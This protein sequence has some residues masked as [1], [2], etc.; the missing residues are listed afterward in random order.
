MIFIFIKIIFDKW[1][2]PNQNNDENDEEHR[3]AELFPAQLLRRYFLYFKPQTNATLK[4]PMKTLAVRGVKGSHLGKLIT[5]RGIIIRVSDV[6]PAVEVNA[7]TCDTCGYEIFQEVKSKTFMP[8]FQC[9]SQQCTRNKH[10]G[11]LF[12]STRASKFSPYQDVKIQELANQ[13]PTGHIPRMLT[14]HINGD[15]V[16]SIF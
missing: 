2:D 7:Y 10:A 12:P 6:K 9:T 8:M 13:V 16:R 14:I 15:L 11:R 4:T 3:T 5:V 1:I